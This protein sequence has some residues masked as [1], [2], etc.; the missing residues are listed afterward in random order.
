M[1]KS[2]FIYVTYINTTPQKLW[3]ALTNPEFQKQYWTGMDIKTDWKPGSKWQLTFPDG[4]IADHGE[5]VEFKPYERIVL[6]WRNVWKTGLSAEGYSRCIMD[7]EPTEEAV[8]LTVTHSIGK[9]KSKLIKAVSGGWPMVLSNLKS[10][11]ET[12]KVIK[13][14][15]DCSKE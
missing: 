12:G 14:K 6:K 1:A 11:L 2:E 3:K 8:K 7:I 10:L 4:S 9:D 5:V 15:S 13:K